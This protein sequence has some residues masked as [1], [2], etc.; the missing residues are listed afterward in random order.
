MVQVGGLLDH[1]EGVWE[2]DW[3]RRR[4]HPL[5]GVLLATCGTILACSVVLAMRGERA[6]QTELAV[7]PSSILAKLETRPASARTIMETAK[8]ALDQLEGKKG[9]AAVSA[10]AKEGGK[11]LAA[12]QGPLSHKPA[13]AGSEVAAKARAVK[14]GAAA[15]Q[16]PVVPLVSSHEVHK[17]M[18]S[19]IKAAA[20]KKQE[21]KAKESKTD[22]MQDRIL[23]AQER[24]AS[25]K[26]KKSNDF[27][28]YERLSEVVDHAK[29]KE[30]E[31]H[32][33]YEEDMDRERS[34]KNRLS[35]LRQK[36]TNHLTGQHARTDLNSYYAQLDAKALKSIPQSI[37]DAHARSTAAAAHYIS[38]MEGHRSRAVGARGRN[39]AERGA[40]MGAKQTVA[41]KELPRVNVWDMHAKLDE[42][43]SAE[44]KLK[45]NSRA[46]DKLI[47]KTEVAKEKSG[48]H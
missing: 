18:K 47:L 30:L 39:G 44:H 45:K 14:G 28:A 16:E 31:A 38:K 3:V 4:R 27:A 5:W 24:L 43:D 23:K 22:R 42:L 48:S 32:D 33:E 1:A 26:L 40:K 20:A 6:E 9:K 21:K 2:F 29:S 15:A 35:R 36:L 34:D 12:K 46:A 25:L 37:K 41:L 8:A 13:R 17:I 19:M 10:L 7:E 11:A